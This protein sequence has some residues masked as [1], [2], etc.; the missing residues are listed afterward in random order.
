MTFDFKVGREVQN[1]AKISDVLGE[2]LMDM[3]GRGVENRRTSFMDVPQG[4]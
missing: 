2:K 1:D 4:K 3:V